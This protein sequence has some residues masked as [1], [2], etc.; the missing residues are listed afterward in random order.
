MTALR[1]KT[2][3]MLQIIVA[4]F[5][6][7][8]KNCYKLC[9]ESI[10]LFFSIL[11]WYG[12]LGLKGKAKLEFIVNMVGNIIGAKQDPLSD[13]CLPADERNTARILETQSTPSLR[14]SRNS[15]YT[16]DIFH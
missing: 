8:V 13:L 4:P 15:R 7:L 6:V 11:I 16:D 2:R 12:N 9:V 5:L 3:A 14:S 10:V 1:F